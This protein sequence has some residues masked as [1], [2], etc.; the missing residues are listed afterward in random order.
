VFVAP[1][2][3]PDVVDRCKEVTDIGKGCDSAYR[4]NHQLIKA[5]FCMLH[6]EASLMID[7]QG[8]DNIENGTEKIGD[9]VC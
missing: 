9:S 7:T 4:G 8:R 2:N 6:A 3:E 5:L 1:P